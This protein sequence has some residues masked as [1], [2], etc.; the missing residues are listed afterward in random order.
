VSEISLRQPTIVIEAKPDTIPARLKALWQ[1]RAFYGFLLKELTLRKARGTMLGF[2]WLIIRPIIP[3]AVL[4]FVG[5]SMPAL[6]TG[7]P[8]PI[9]FLSGYIPFLVF[10]S[11]LRYVPRS[12]RWAQS[13]MRRTY[14]P[15]L[16]V[17]LAGFGTTLIELGVMVAAFGI[18]LAIGAWRGQP[19]PLELGWQ[20][21]WLLPCLLTAFL[22]ALSVGMTFSVVA[23][24]FPDVIF[25]LRIFSMLAMLA[26]P[27]MYPVRFVPEPYL[28][29]LYTFNPMAQVVLTSRW[30]LTGQGVFELPYLLLSFGT[31]LVMLMAAVWF[32]LRAETHLGDQM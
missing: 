1:Y 6:D 12:L 27:V 20:T 2:W 21:L 24:F 7:I 31:T 18:L 22:L 3:A 19:F 30:A 5:S 14:F 23:L 4:I 10:Q 29:A 11:G 28:W 16:L 26:T 25:S 9:F 13:I 15:R 32:F 8:Y 17:P